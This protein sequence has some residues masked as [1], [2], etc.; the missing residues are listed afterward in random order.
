MGIKLNN[1]KGTH[2]RWKRSFLIKELEKR[3]LYPA[4]R[5]DIKD[6]DDRNER[7]LVDFAT[8]GTALSVN[9][10]LAA[11]AMNT[12]G[13]R[14][15]RQATYE[16]LVSGQIQETKLATSLA[17][18]LLALQIW[19]ARNMDRV[20]A[21]EKPYDSSRFEAIGLCLSSCLAFGWNNIAKKLGNVT[22]QMLPLAAYTDANPFLKASYHPNRRCFPWFVIKL[23]ADWTGQKLKEPLPRHPYPS[24]VYDEM[25]DCWREPDPEKLIEP[26]LAVCDWHT[27]ECM[28]TA[29][30]EPSKDLD[31]SSDPY[32][33]WPVEIHMLYRLRESLGLTNPQSLDHP[34]MQT[35]L[36]TYL[37]PQPF[38]DDILLKRITEKALLEYP[39][40]AQLL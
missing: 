39:T 26:F 8:H 15:M 28:Y 27:H 30:M 40:L 18:R 38:P 21:G 17:Y 25:L 3:I 22:L 35:A 24:P 31:F 33:G 37:P 13:L 29:S 7:E 23:F 10:I 11:V 1:R 14:L 32:M 9:S 2:K 5:P 20:R 12:H 16:S 34:L 4:D 19:H 6:F 36:A